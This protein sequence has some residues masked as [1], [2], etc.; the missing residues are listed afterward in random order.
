MKHHYLP[1]LLVLLCSSSGVFAQNLKPGLWQITTTMQGGGQDISAA[2]AMVQKKL[3]ALPADQRKRMQDML[4][5]QG[6]QMGDASGDGLNLKVCM[7]QDM[8]DRHELAP[9]KGDCMHT[10][11][12]RVGATM[13][14]SFQCTQP[15]ASGQGEV[16]FISP[17]AYSVKMT[18][19]SSADGTPRTIDMQ[20][21]GRWL[22]SRCG[23]IK[24]LAAPKQQG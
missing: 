24:P 7:T 1:A 10:V 14:Y 21:N 12:P 4:A 11:G 16:T 6:V 8:V 17:E 5:K 23:D 20:S 2:M 9:Q 3:A 19:T 13:P 18:A 15:P 22:D